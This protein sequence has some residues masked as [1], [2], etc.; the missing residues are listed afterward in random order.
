M[1][2]IV[3]LRNS[4]S[5]T[6]FQLLDEEEQEIVTRLVTHSQSEPVLWPLVST[7]SGDSFSDS[8]L[9]GSQLEIARMNRNPH[10][11]IVDYGQEEII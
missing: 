2:P 9:H 3:Q 4:S 1:P 11:V 5:Q 8:H 7:P 6:D 10:I